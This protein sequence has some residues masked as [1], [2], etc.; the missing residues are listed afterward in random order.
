MTTACAAVTATATATTVTTVAV[1]SWAFALWTEVAELTGEFGVK[2]VFEAHFDDVAGRSGLVA[3]PIV[4]TVFAALTTRCT[5][6]AAT[7][8]V[9]TAATVSAATAGA[10]RGALRDIELFG[11]H[12]ADLALV[13]DLFDLDL[14]DLA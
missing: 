8:I 12:Q 3:T 14:D 7:T 2:A 6:F 10:A 1:S 5:L 4:A 13:V 9:V 11:E